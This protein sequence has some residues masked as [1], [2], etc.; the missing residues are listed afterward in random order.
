MKIDILENSQKPC[1]DCGDPFGTIFAADGGICTTILC[2][3]CITIYT[4]EDGFE[5]ED[6]S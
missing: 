4:N 1:E 6:E 3:Q 2:F 5:F